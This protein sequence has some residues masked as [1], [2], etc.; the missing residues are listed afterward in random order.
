MAAGDTMV[1]RRLPT[2]VN[3][4]TGRPDVNLNM[5]TE[6]GDYTGPVVGYTGDLAAVFFLKPNAHDEGVV[7]HARSVQHV[8]SPP[9]TF[10]EEEDGTLT[11]AASISDLRSSYPEEWKG[12]KSDGWHGFLE[13]GVWRQV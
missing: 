2:E 12:E 5:P 6:P 13:H 9:H 8:T 1:G 3:A 11:I 7:A 10:T 4:E